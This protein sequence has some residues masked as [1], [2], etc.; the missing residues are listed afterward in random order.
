IPSLK[1]KA[2]DVMD[3]ADF[4]TLH[5]QSSGAPNV[6]V[7]QYAIANGITSGGG[8]FVIGQGTTGTR[9]LHGCTPDGGVIFTDGASPDANCYYRQFSGDVHLSWYGPSNAATNSACIP[10][11]G[12]RASCDESS[13]L[14]DAL[15][16]ALTY[17]NGRVTTDGIPIVVNESLVIPAG[18]ALDCGG[19]PNG[20]LNQNQSGSIYYW[21]LPN[22]L[23]LN[24]SVTITVGGSGT[25]ASLDSCAIIPTWYAPSSSPFKLPAQSTTDVLKLTN[26]F[27]GT[28]VMC[29]GTKCG[30]SHLFIAGFDTCID[31]NGAAESDLGSFNLECNIPLYVHNEGSGMHV[32]HVQIKQYLEQNLRD[33][34]GNRIDQV[35]DAIIGIGSDSGGSGQCAGIT[36]T[37]IDVATPSSVPTLPWSSTGLPLLIGGLGQIADFSVNGNTVTDDSA[38]VMVPADAGKGYGASDVFAG[39]SVTDSLGYIPSSTGPPFLLLCIECLRQRG[40]NRPILPGGFHGGAG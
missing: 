2:Q 31:A 22:T 35:Q 28:A 25:P 13:A 19:V 18:A 3:F 23:V 38:E 36:C 39:Q 10:P 9:P 7:E 40:R 15:N 4:S 1:T 20:Y 34:N 27:T 17:G 6:N 29:G 37:Y 24:P 11:T 26:F 8:Q 12:T 21:T 32:G 5:G 30:M 16:A 14:T 33:L